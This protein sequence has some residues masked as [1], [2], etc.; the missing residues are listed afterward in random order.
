[1]ETSMM[2]QGIEIGFFS[3]ENQSV[4]DNCKTLFQDVIQCVYHVWN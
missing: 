4:V 3:G 2:K 1:M